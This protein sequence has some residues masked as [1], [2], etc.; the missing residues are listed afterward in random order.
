MGLLLWAAWTDLSRRLILN[1][2]SLLLL[3]LWPAHILLSP[4]PVAP[5]PHLAVGLAVFVVGY[6]LWL[7]GTLGGGDAKL[8]GAV[9]LWA[10]PEHA[11]SFL[12]VTACLGGVL[13][14]AYLAFVHSKPIL[15]YTACRLGLPDRVAALALAENERAP[16]LPYAVA[17]AGGGV[18]LLP[19][20]T[21]L[22]SGIVA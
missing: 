16:T 22:F 8:L 18:W 10:G 1:R 14:L 2:V 17:I 12:L 20:L 11:P 19:R 3:A 21:P 5:W 4:G 6:A 15:A 7:G 9:A 13:A